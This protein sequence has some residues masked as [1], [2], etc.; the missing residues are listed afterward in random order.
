MNWSGAPRRAAKGRVGIFRVSPE[1]LA[2]NKSEQEKRF[3][4]A[5]VSTSA[6]KEQAS[7]AEWL[8]AATART[9][10]ASDVAAER[11]RASAAAAFHGDPPR[12][13]FAAR[14]RQPAK[15]GDFPPG[16]SDLLGLVLNAL[17]WDLAV[18][19]VYLSV[20]VEE[21]WVTIAGEVAYPYQ[22]SCAEADACRVSGVRGVSN[23]IEIKPTG[24]PASV[25]AETCGGGAR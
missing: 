8:M 25:P 11:N 7:A 23:E 3:G 18:P 15:I 22:K 17:Y 16:D 14:R 13:E 5:R 21:G 24:T 6:G 20:R 10:V 1:R 4:E 19:S 9:F 2:A 12:A